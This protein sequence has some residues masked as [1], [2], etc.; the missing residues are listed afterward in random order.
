M[1]WWGIRGHPAPDHFPLYSALGAFPH[2]HHPPAA[3]WKPEEP[4]L[5]FFLHQ[6]V[7]QNQSGLRARSFQLTRITI[8]STISYRVLTEVL[9]NTFMRSRDVFIITL[10]RCRVWRKL[11]WWN[12]RHKTQPA[13]RYVDGSWKD[14]VFLS[15]IK[16]TRDAKEV[17]LSKLYEGAC[18]RGWT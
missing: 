2:R 12:F 10:Q 5:P 14:A 6:P 18:S 7:D 1:S 13:G 16:K 17:T 4:Y 11:W 15:L 8:S 3:R 9:I